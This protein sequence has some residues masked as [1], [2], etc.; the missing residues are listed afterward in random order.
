M[1]LVAVPLLSIYSKGEKSTIANN[2][3]QMLLNKHG[4]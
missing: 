4:K 1:K 2:E 3:L